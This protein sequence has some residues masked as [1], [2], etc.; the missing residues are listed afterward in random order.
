MSLTDPQ[1]ALAEASSFIDYLVGLAGLGQLVHALAADGG[2]TATDADDFVYL[3]LGLAGMAER[4]EQLAASQ[5][6]VTTPAEVS[7]YPGTGRW[8]R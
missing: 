4:V 1:P 7:G 6:G 8:L 3:L 5:A 2:S